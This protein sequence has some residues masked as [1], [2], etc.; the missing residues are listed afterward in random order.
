MREYKN[1]FFFQ[2][3]DY[4]DGMG[5]GREGEREEKFGNHSIPF[6]NHFFLLLWFCHGGKNQKKKKMQLL[7]NLCSG[8]RIQFYP[9]LLQASAATTPCVIFAFSCW[10]SWWNWWKNQDKRKKLT[11]TVKQK[12]KGSQVLTLQ[13]LF[14]K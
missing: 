12:Q 3:E 6:L 5:M 10:W 11:E 9:Y 1:Y 4:R 7:F 14:W 8:N 13:N 2:G